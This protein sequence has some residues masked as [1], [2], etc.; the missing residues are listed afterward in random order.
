MESY[1]MITQINDFIF[2]PRSIYYSGIFRDSSD[3]EVFHQT[4]QTI[5]KAAHE[6]VDTN[7][8][9]SRKDIITGLTVYSTRYN[10]L[11]RIDILDVSAKLLTER[12]YSVTAV[13]DGF[14]Y[15]LYAQ[16]FALQEMG[17][18]VSS[19]R[20]HSVK[21]NRNYDIPI[22]DTAEITRFESVLDKIRS[23]DLTKPF[24]PN[25]NKCR[26]CIYNPLCDLFEPGEI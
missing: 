1:L 9:S 19:L 6:T 24:N 18:E 22:P 26:R 20:L 10:L 2:C 25:P 8:Y 12:K 14:K 3:C 11:G 16:Y 4:P 13:Y 7:T 21:D 5:G 15:Q 23:F 17:F